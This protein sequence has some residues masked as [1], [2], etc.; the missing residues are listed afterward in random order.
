MN[1]ISGTRNNFTYVF[2]WPFGNASF[3]DVTQ[4]LGS[5]FTQIDSSLVDNLNR[6]LWSM[7][8]GS[9]AVYCSFKR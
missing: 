1:D 2:R 9:S 7:G 5:F 3:N 6:R 8:I 4:H